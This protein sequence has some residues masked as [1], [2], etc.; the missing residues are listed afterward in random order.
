MSSIGAADTAADN[1]AQEGSA[2]KKRRQWARM[3][4]VT[5]GFA[6]GIAACATTSLQ[7]EGLLSQAGFR[8]IPADTPAKLAHLKTLPERRLVGRTSK[9]GKK[10]YVYADPDG[11][12]CLYMGNPTQYQSYQGLAQQQQAQQSHGVEEAREWEEQNSGL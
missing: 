6:L 2:M 4:L 11:C 1:S 3:T 7:T 12:K 8:Q 9:D 5:V 10:Y